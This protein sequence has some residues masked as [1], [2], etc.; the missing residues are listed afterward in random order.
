M[1]FLIV[2][3]LLLAFVLFIQNPGLATVAVIAGF[4]VFWS[5]R[6]VMKPM[7]LLEHELQGDPPEVRTWGNIWGWV[8]AMIVGIA[9]AI[10]ALG[11]I[12]MLPK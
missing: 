4:V 10:A 12:T 2:S 6:F 9:A 1:R 3:L 5:I 11:I 7:E 8:V